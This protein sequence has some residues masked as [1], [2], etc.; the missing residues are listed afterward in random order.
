M[1]K[2]NNTLVNHFPRIISPR[3]HGLGTRLE[4]YSFQLFIR[5]EC[6]KP[7]GRN[8]RT[9][10]FRRDSSCS[11]MVHME[12]WLISTNDS[13]CRGLNGKCGVNL[14]NPW[15][16]VSE[17]LLC[18]S[19]SSPLCYLWSEVRKHRNYLHISMNFSPNYIDVTSVRWCLW[20]NVI[21]QAVSRDRQD[22]FWTWTWFCGSLNIKT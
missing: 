1:S 16:F 5:P 10:V 3:G 22:F 9:L 19:A 13:S 17:D 6:Y 20:L 12:G 11:H 14:R 8:R 2:K 7:S 18:F 21:K 15:L 4:R